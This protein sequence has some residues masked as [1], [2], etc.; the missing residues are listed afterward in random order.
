M[1]VTH[2]HENESDTMSVARVVARSSSMKLCTY[3][4][5]THPLVSTFDASSDKVAA[6][7]A[8]LTAI[9]PM[10]KTDLVFILNFS[11]CGASVVEPTNCAAT[12]AEGVP[13]ISLHCPRARSSELRK[14]SSGVLAIVA[15]DV[16]VLTCF[17]GPES[18]LHFALARAA[19]T[20]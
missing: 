13:E 16:S 4:A 14:H 11:V 8:A 9:A 19:R 18:Q 15:R 5:L 6:G 1:H 20:H 10:A 7:A 2:P 12:N 3:D 17:A